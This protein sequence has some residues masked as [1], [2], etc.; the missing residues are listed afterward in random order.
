[1]G[2]SMGGLTAL[3]LITSYPDRVA[4]AI[5]GA[6]G[7]GNIDSESSEFEDIVT[8]IKQ[9]GVL[10]SVKRLASAMGKLEVHYIDGGTHNNT[11]KRVSDFI[12]V[13]TTR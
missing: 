12:T 10:D 3:Q 1:M 8:A 9:D 13:Q 2:Y 7:W 4:S 6:A 11:G 5:V